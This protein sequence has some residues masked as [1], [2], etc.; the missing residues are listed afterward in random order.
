MQTGKY[1][2]IGLIGN[3][4][5]SAIYAVNNGIADIN[6][7][8]IYHLFYKNY[9]HDLLQ[10]AVTMIKVGDTI[11]YG[12][13]VWKENTHPQHITP[14][15]SYVEDGYRYCDEFYLEECGMTRKERVYAYGEHKLIFETEIKNETEQIQKI[16]CYGYA[17]IRND[18]QIE[19]AELTADM[20]GVHTGNV[21]IGMETLKREEI[22]LVE[23]SPTD[24]AYQTFLDVLEKRQQ[25]KEL[26][27][28][29][30]LG[31][32]QGGEYTLQ[33]GETLE[34]C[35]SLVFADNYA[36]LK[37]ELDKYRSQSN[38]HMKR[39][40]ER[41]AADFYW[42]SWMQEGREISGEDRITEAAKI[43]LVS[44]KAVCVG[45]YIPADLTG[46]YFC[47]KMPCYYAR[48]SIMVARAF[49]LS[50]HF[51][52]CR[53]ILLYL[54]QRKRKANGEFYQRYDGYGEPNEGANNNV[55]HQIDSIGYFCRMIYE[56][57]KET[58]ELLAQESLLEELTDVI[59]HAEQ[60]FGM[61]GPEG[62][63]NEG[64]FGGAFITSSNMFI[65]GGIK[66]AEALF[67]ILG[68]VTYE[69]KCEEICK[70]IYQGIQI[71]YNEKIGRYDYGYVKYHDHPVRK[72][73]TPQYFGPLYG[74]PNDEHMKA[75][76][77][78]FLKYASF[79]EDGIGYSEQEYHHG[80]W[81]FNTLAC[82]EYCK[83]NGEREEYQKKM[84]WAVRHSNQYGLMPEAVDADNEEVC[85]INPLSWACA[86]F[87]AS[88]F[89]ERK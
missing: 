40:N 56:F 13:K 34:L 27:T 80:P 77:Q 30:R 44:M 35:W 24:F 3:E 2:G 22:Y 14:E 68:N 7:T 64:V 53:A 33:P 15:N 73:D 67:K 12:N 28:S 9:A 75:T 25:R 4:N 54:L 16:H 41:Q 6:G 60:K 83:Q 66:A 70:Q 82:A 76:H 46:H 85:F 58:G 84:E 47:N 5:L 61:V 50:G 71:T 8:G 32:V 11:Y 88:Y 37:Q 74:Y 49:F 55:F 36:M 21:Y 59:F 20:F 51:R 45:G 63:V 78:Y 18:R 26:Q 29:C 57:Y 1:T 89:S 69:K 19:V 42:Q 10:S 79:F 31:Y 17:A 81:L 48:D 43:N 72:Y 39:Q 65:Y 62:G 86:E 23:D 87:V 38:L 52:E